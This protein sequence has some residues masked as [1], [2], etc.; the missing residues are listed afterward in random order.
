MKIDIKNQEE[1]ETSSVIRSYFYDT[2]TQ[3][4]LVSFGGPN[5]NRLYAYHGV[6]YATFRN[7]K[8]SKSKGSAFNRL[9]RNRFDDQCV[10]SVENT[11]IGVV[12]F[13]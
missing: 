3:T 5:V 12:R 9:I 1:V 11:S 13:F 2:K 7:F 6:P 10:V 4:L 8:R